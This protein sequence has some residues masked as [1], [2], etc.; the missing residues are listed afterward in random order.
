VAQRLPG[1]E[2][3]LQAVSMAEAA[4]VPQ[5][6]HL[7]ALSPIDDIR[8]SAAYRREAALTLLRDLLRRL[9]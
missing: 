8:A 2:A 4:Q 7:A 9:A 1:L 3:A 6:A 5:A